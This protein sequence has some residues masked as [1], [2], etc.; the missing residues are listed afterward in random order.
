MRTLKTGMFGS[1]D[2]KR[3][4]DVPALA[5]TMAS[6][7]FAK[8]VAFLKVYCVA[9]R[10]TS[11]AHQALL[12]AFIEKLQRE[13]GKHKT[14]GVYTVDVCAEAGPAAELV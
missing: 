14:C 1:S 10:L 5:I 2:F 3:C 12:T 13:T 9:H 4:Y 11:D 8:V 7:V 6:E